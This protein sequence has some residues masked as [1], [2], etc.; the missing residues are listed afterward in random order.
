MTTK[1]QQI[2]DLI[3]SI[4]IL[5]GVSLIKELESVFNIELMQPSKT[6]TTIVSKENTINKENV[7]DKEKTKFNLKI[8]SF[9]ADKKIPVLKAIR[10]VTG[11]GLKESKDIIDNLPKII[12][13]NISKDEVDKYKKE[14]EEAG[15]QVEIY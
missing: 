4:T 6:N 5:E 10:S 1:I 14:I 2:V 3:K 12:K 13:E 8:L 9:I 11:L 15:G 7:E